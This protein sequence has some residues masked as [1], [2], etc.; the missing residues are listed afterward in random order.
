[1]AIIYG[2]VKA[3]GKSE[4]KAHERF[5]RN[6]PFIVT[7][8]VDVGE[9]SAKIGGKTYTANK[10]EVLIIPANTLHDITMPYDSTISYSHVFAK[11]MGEDILYGYSI[12]HII[13]GDC[14]KIIAENNRVLSKAYKETSLLAK[15]TCDRAVSSIITEILCQ[16]ETERKDSLEE[17]WLS[18]IRTYI[19][20]NIKRGITLSSLAA[21]TSMSKSRFCEKFKKLTGVSPINYVNRMKMEYSAQ[22]LLSGESIKSIVDMLG[23]C[24][25][26]YFSRLFKKTMGKGPREYLQDY[27]RNF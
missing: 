9:Y 22:Q 16:P 11:E 26:A 21:Y 19:S 2:C 27:N 5:G 6:F 8:A 25:E 3:E 14:A 24:D 18:D 17:M 10:D 15:L 1:M 13:K 12:P 23:M 7:V 4:K 20:E